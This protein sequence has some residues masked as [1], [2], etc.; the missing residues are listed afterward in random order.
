MRSR[1]SLFIFRSDWR[2]ST[3]QY[4]KVLS[5]N[6]DTSDSDEIEMNDLIE[7]R[8]ESMIEIFLR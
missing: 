4:L 5:W 3:E 8:V 2:K 7:Q 1:F 6:T